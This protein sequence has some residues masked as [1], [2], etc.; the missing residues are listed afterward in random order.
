MK[1]HT[2]YYLIFRATI[3][4]LS[5]VFHFRRYKERGK[6]YRGKQSLKNPSDMIDDGSGD[7]MRGFG[8]TCREIK[9]VGKYYHINVNIHIH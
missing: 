9:I 4:E 2:N 1:N 3:I 8:R 7:Q 5:A 6:K